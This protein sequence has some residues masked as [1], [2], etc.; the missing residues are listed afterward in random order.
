MGIRD[1]FSSIR[2][3]GRGGGTQ[4]DQGVCEGRLSAGGAWLGSGGLRSGAVR[5]QATRDQAGGCGCN[6]RSRFRER[7]LSQSRFCTGHGGCRG[8]CRQRSGSRTPPV[9]VRCIGCQRSGLHQRGTGFLHGCGIDQTGFMR[10]GSDGD[11]I[12]SSGGS[13]RAGRIH[14][15]REQGHGGRAEPDS[16]LS[17]PMDRT[18]WVLWGHGSTFP[19]RRERMSCSRGRECSTHGRRMRQ[20]PGSC[21]REGD[22]EQNLS[23]LDHIPTARTAGAVRI[24][25]S[26]R[27]V[28]PWEGSRVTGTDMDEVIRRSSNI[29]LLDWRSRDRKSPAFWRTQL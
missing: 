14:A 19:D 1:G 23:D 25:R 3:N 15:S 8:W 21:K 9:G 4:L 28:L 18:A 7:G 26:Q 11:R 20:P 12:G 24:P 16:R 22:R 5:T 17:D 6:D 10:C 27:Q 13:R 29:R 2:N